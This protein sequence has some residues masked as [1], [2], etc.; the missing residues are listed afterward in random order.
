MYNSSVKTCCLITISLLWLSYTIGQDNSLIFN[1]LNRSS[2]LPNNTINDITQDEL[3]FIWF[4]TNDGL[5]RYDSPTQMKI[6]RKGDIGL[7]SSNIRCIHSTK[8]STLWIGTD[9]GGLTEL[10]ITTL[11]FQNY[12]STEAFPYAITNDVVTAFHLD[13]KGNKWIGTEEG[14]NIITC[15]SSKRISFKENKNRYPE[16]A[17][18]SII[19]DDKGWIWIGT[20]GQGQGIYLYIPDEENINDSI[21]FKM[22]TPSNIESSNNVWSIIQDNSHNYWIATHGA[23]LFYMSIPDSIDI[24][25][26]YDDWNPNFKNYSFSSKPS[27]SLDSDIVYDINKDN[28]GNLWIATVAGLKIL[29]NFDINKPI[30]EQNVE[31]HTSMPFNETSIIGDILSKLYFDKNNIMWIGAFKGVSQYHQYANQFDFIKITSNEQRSRN[32]VVNIEQIN[33]HEVLMATDNQGALIYNTDKGFIDYSKTDFLPKSFKSIYDICLDSGNKHYLAVRN[34]ILHVDLD[35]QIFK[36]HKLPDSLINRYG[37][38][39]IK[40]VFKDNENK[41]WCGSEYGLFILDN[42]QLNPTLKPYLEN[43]LSD[44]SITHIFQDSRNNIWISTYNGLNKLVKTGEEYLIRIFKRA[45]EEDKNTIPQNQILSIGEYDNHIYLGARNGIFSL[46]LDSETFN[47]LDFQIDRH[48]IADFSISE[49]GIL[50]ASTS[51]GILKCDLVNSEINFFE[52]TEGIGQVIMRPNTVTI[53]ED[54]KIY[55]GGSN[56]FLKI[57]PETIIENDTPPEVYITDITTI[58]SSGSYT[59]NGLN[60]DSI[61][62]SADNYSLS[63]DFAGLNYYQIEKNKFKYKLEGFDEDWVSAKPGQKAIYTNLKYGNYTLRVKAANSKGIWNEE[64][65]DLIIIVKSYLWERTWFRIFTVLFIGIILWIIFK[66]FTK[67]INQ[68]NKIL[69]DFN[70]SLNT[71]IANKKEAEAALLD[72]EKSMTVLLEKLDNSNKELVRSNKDLE[73]FAFIVSHDMK[74]PLR[75]IGSFTNLLKKKYSAT[76]DENAQVYINFITGGVNRLSDLIHSI[77]EYSVT[78]NKEIEF[79][80]A[81]LNQIITNKIADLN[82]F[83]VDKN[84]EVNLKNKLPVINCVGDQIGMVFYN[85]ILNGLKFNTSEKPTVQISAVKNEKNW[86]F[87][88]RD[89]GIGIPKEHQKQVFELFKRLHRKEEFEGTGIGLALT[90]K[91]IHNHQ[92]KLWIDSAQGQGTTI[93]FTLPIS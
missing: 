92:G 37:V 11:E 87:A 40:N 26:Q 39:P 22:F 79:T 18:L 62:V 16:G 54:Q 32:L 43:Q 84:A 78:G 48:N 52:E 68:R 19:E 1:S 80:R 71:E 7:L 56:G 59:T 55:F 12:N 10:N 51:D 41:I 25:N 29:K 21:S 50:W 20:W 73:Q 91:I 45:S 47:N 30:S 36:F 15:D 44:V 34:G 70:E 42:N 49:T 2:G 23:G 86:E 90:S 5:V 88:I 83:I 82:Q 64:T 66:L 69:S 33:K 77:L 38:F 53:N 67:R 28:H 6:F 14:L 76:L 4:A 35:K 60:L 31:T 81:D 61:T 46:N 63:V 75:T 3:G 85:I 13:S 9:F 74:E 57:D 72:R 24:N 65:A 27:E 8:D 58:N 17:I 93:F 89:N